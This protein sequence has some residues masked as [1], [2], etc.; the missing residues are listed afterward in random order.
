MVG[1]NDVRTSPRHPASVAARLAD[2]VC[3][4][5]HCRGESWFQRLMGT[6]QGHSPVRSLLASDPFPDHPPKYIRA[7]LYDYHFAD[8][9]TYART[10]Q[11]WARRLEGLYFPRVSLA[12]FQRLSGTG[13]FHWE[14]LRRPTTPAAGGGR[15][16]RRS[17]L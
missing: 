11:W 6:A 4:I 14:W 1:V 10:G 13:V 3:R 12:D 7:E 16:L 15:R 8:S 17:L 2:V 9:A 5:R